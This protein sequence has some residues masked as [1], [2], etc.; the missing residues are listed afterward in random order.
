M[1]SV[2]W[3]CGSERCGGGG[4][5]WMG[6]PGTRS[7]AGAVTP[8]A[9]LPGAHRDARAACADGMRA[10]GCGAAWRDAAV[11]T[12][13]LAA[14]LAGWLGSRPLLLHH[15][16]GGGRWCRASGSRASHPPSQGTPHATAPCTAPRAP[17]MRAWRC[18]WAPSRE[19]D[20]TASEPGNSA[21]NQK[22]KEMRQ[23]QK[24]TTQ[25]PPQPACCACLLVAGPPAQQPRLAAELAGWLA[26]STR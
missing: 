9:M 6:P 25:V 8:G 2:R 12:G 7:S 22:Q 10:A 26:Q 4:C 24:E 17:R 20:S 19:V 3:P 18:Q 15:A 13:G 14:G 21:R 1:A 5:G 23:R 11:L 16:P